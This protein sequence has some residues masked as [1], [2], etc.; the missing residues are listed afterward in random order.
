MGYILHI[1]WCRISCIN[2]I[3]GKYAKELEDENVGFQDVP[4]KD[5]SEDGRNTFFLRGGWLETTHAV[6]HV[7]EV[8]EV[9]HNGRFFQLFPL[10]LTR[11]LLNGSHFGEDEINAHA[12]S[13]WGI[14][15]K[16]KMHE[17]WGPV[18]FYDPLFELLSFAV[19]RLSYR[20]SFDHWRHWGYQWTLSWY[21]DGGAL[22][23]IFWG[24]KVAEDEGSSVPTWGGAKVS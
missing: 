5:W 10:F 20:G 15:R 23:V 22:S 12:W 24:A 19:L 9:C 3:N 1:N 13:I 8:H 16:T 11:G 21:F 6:W 17:V 18:S 14:S 7:F 4:Q 2:C